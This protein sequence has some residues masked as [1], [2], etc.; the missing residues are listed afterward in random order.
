MKK[1]PAPRRPSARKVQAARERIA[2]LRKAL[3]EIELLCSGSLSERM[4][5]CG[6]PTC[7]CA[8]DP[9]ARHGPY[10]EWGRMRAGKL[11]HRYVTAEQA[12]ELRKAIDNHRLVKKLLR[13]WEVDSELLI[14][15]EQ[16]TEP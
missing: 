12:L 7:R 2:K 10:Y 4:M 9:S 5:K 16:P 1:S 3:G 15:A 8:T 14:D 13:D 11:A 6:K